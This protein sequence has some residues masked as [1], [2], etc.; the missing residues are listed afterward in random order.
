MP[1]KEAL[2]PSNSIST[3]HRARQ[4]RKRRRRSAKRKEEMG[5]MGKVKCGGKAE[6]KAAARNYTKRE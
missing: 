4:A 2:L 1:R 5:K 3:H 6:G